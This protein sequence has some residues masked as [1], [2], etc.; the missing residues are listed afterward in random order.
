M[1]EIDS[2]LKRILLNMKYNSKNSLNENIEDVDMFINEQVAPNLTGNPFGKNIFVNP[3][4]NLAPVVKKKVEKKTAVDPNIPKGKVIPQGKNQVMQFQDY[5]F[6]VVDKL[7]TKNPKEKVKTQL[8]GSPCT[9]TTATK[10]VWDNR[11]KQYNKNWWFDDPKY[12]AYILGIKTPQGKDGIKSFQKWFLEHKEGAKMGAKGLYT[13]ALCLKPCTLQQA[14]DGKMGKGTK[15]AWEKYKNEYKKLNKEWF[16]DSEYDKNV[17][18][19]KTKETKIAQIFV[20]EPGNPSG[21]NGNSGNFGTD[22]W[23]TLKKNLKSSEK[24]AKYMVKNYG[25][26]YNTA[27]FPYPKPYTKE[28]LQWLIKDAK[29]LVQVQKKQKEDKDMF[30]RFETKAMVSDRLGRGYG[31]SSGQFDTQMRGMGFKPQY[32]LKSEAE[33]EQ[34][35][36]ATGVLY[37]SAVEWNNVLAEVKDEIYEKCNRPLRVGKGPNG[38][39][40][41]NPGEI[42][43]FYGGLWVYKANSPKAVCG[44]RYNKEQQLLL[45]GQGELVMPNGQRE[46]VS[47]SWNKWLEWQTPG[48]GADQ[49]KYEKIHNVLTVIELGAMVISF[50]A[51]PFAPVFQ[52]VSFAAGMGDS[53]VYY[54]QGDKYMGTMMLVLNIVG[55]DEIYDLFKGAKT[56]TKLGKAGVEELAEKSVKGG[57]K[58]ADEVVANSLKKEMVERQTK[59]SLITKRTAAENF[60]KNFTGVALNKKWGWNVLFTVYYRMNKVLSTPIKLTLKFGGSMVSVDLLYLAIYGNDND[61]KYSALA[62]YIDMLY[63]D[64]KTPEDYK[65]DFK[66]IQD[67]MSE[68]GKELEQRNDEIA[69]SSTAVN[70][71]VGMD[72]TKVDSETVLLAKARAIVE[73][74]GGGKPKTTTGTA[75]KGGGANYNFVDIVY[76]QSIPLNSVKEENKVITLGMTGDTIV[77]IQKMLNDAGYRAPNN[78]IFDNITMGWVTDFQTDNGLKNREGTIDKETLIALETKQLKNK[79]CSEQIQV[80]LN[81]GWSETNNVGYLKNKKSAL[82]QVY[83]VDCG[84]QRY[85]IKTSNSGGG[86]SPINKTM[87]DVE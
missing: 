31:G 32:V 77:T 4:T 16:Y 83:M 55:A 86:Q 76:S 2:N 58:G 15:A 39:W 84:G 48:G 5:I 36:K 12:T 74:M 81:S 25:W 35:K 9:Y 53:M 37:N 23:Q 49:Q 59:L 18:G 40:Y 1:N 24:Q 66:L 43:K 38:F 57:L 20:F 85:F 22:L 10:G 60:I 54:E 78:G 27:V 8:C 71:L 50:F 67:A 79:T 70:Q 69:G 42:C 7:T 30:S 45:E 14:L 51:G 21:Y 26:S 17:E 61:R 13:T 63:G 82:Q 34:I 75:V 56:M 33:A 44:C 72:W 29:K 6:F 62:P 28:D 19:L 73:S 64:G 87:L 3:N 11:P 47:V 46:F 52:V 65:K 41:V 68:M 80:L